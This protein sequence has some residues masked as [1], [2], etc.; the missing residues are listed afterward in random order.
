MP[1]RMPRERPESIA[2]ALGMMLKTVR[3][4]ADKTQTDMSQAVR[5]SEGALSRFETGK[6]VPR[7]EIFSLWVTECEVRDP[8]LRA[9]EYLWWL[10][11]TQ[12]DPGEAQLIPWYEMEAAA[13]TLRYW[14]PLQIPGWAQTE[15]YARALFSVWGYSQSRVDDLVASRLER[16]QMLMRPDPPD[17]TL[18]VWQRVLDT[19]IG[20]PAIMRDQIARLLELSERPG[21]HIQVLPSDGA[22]M[23][24]GGAIH[25]ATTS[26][27]EVLLAEGLVE[28][29]VVADPTRVREASTTFT[30]IRS[31]ALRRSESRNAMTEAMER[32]SK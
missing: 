4:A 9:M 12:D 25:L 14:A 32:W 5:V 31:D 24:L 15:D 6:R 8:L 17:V 26:T 13:H 16:Q 19:L 29:R 30:S 1:A 20:S 21:I 10:A 7:E 27:T 2:N 18:V 23:G 3:M 22:N 28:D 11:R